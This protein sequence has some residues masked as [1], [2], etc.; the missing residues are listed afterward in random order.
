M[1]FLHDSRTSDLLQ[2]IDEHES[3]TGTDQSEANIKC[4]KIS[5]IT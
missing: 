2:A 4:S 5:T 1:W 3:D